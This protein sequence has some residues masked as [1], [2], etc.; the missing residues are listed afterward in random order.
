M[1]FATILF[2]ALEVKNFFFGLALPLS[3]GELDFSV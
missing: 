2:S 3:V 1:S